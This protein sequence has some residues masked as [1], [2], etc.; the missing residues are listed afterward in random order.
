MSDVRVLIVRHG[1]H[2]GRKLSRYMGRSLTYLRRQRPD[3]YQHLVFHHTGKPPPALDGIGAVVFW[4]WCPLRERHPACYE[5]AVRVADEARKNSILLINPPWALSDLGKSRQARLWRETGIPTPEVERFETLESLKK[6]AGRLVFPLVLRGDLTHFQK[7]MR[8]V[9][10]PDELLAL[11][12]GD[13]LFPCAASPFID[14]R[15]G[16]R[17]TQP[18]SAYARLFH[19]KRLIVANGV[20]RTKHVM[21][22]TSPIVGAKTSIFRKTESFGGLETPFLL[23]PLHREC[24]EHDLSYWRQEEEHRD[25]MLK[26][27]RALGLQFAAIDY[28]SLSDG[29][30]IL[31]EANADFGIPRLK[32]I[33]LPHRRRAA[34]RLVSYHEAIGKFLSE[35]LTALSA[36]P[37]KAVPSLS[38]T[39]G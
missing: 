13:L 17:D 19:K 36:S 18:K 26:A 12:T 35:L 1:E 2:R 37:A 34:E 6:A 24:V 20:I 21:F 39:A 7:A 15:S 27:C 9:R 4:L 8:I 22:S 25:L 11:R 32:S 10:D 29:T 3:V 33:M 28:S 38:I 16:Y 30:P 23:W 31:W 5:E 14:V